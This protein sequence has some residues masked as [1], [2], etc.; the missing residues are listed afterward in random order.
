VTAQAGSR[1]V[2]LALACLAHVGIVLLLVYGIDAVRYRA[3]AREA[4]PLLLTLIDELV[5]PTPVPAEIPSPV[6]TP[7]SEVF[8]GPLPEVESSGSAFAPPV[9]DSVPRVD[10][11]DERRREVV[12]VACAELRRLDRVAALAKGCESPSGAQHIVQ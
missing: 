1:T 8:A 2:I 10:W 11:V 6:L 3:P 9:S 5:H 12:H 4:E 7:P